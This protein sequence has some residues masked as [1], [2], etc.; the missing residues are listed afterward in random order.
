MLNILHKSMAVAVVPFVALVAATEAAANE[1]VAE[2]Y[3][4]KRIEFIIGSAAGGAYDQW[5]RLIARHMDRHI[6]GNPS[7]LPKNMPGAGQIIAT[8]HL[9]NRAPRDGTAIGMF[10]RNI[11]M[12]ALLKHP[13]I[14]F[15][16]SEFNWIG[17]P[18]LTNRVCVAR[19]GAKVQKGEDVFMHELLVGGAGI[20]TAV[21]NTPVVL[22]GVLGTKFKVVEG[23]KSASEV[24]LAIQRGEV[25]GICQ[26]MSGLE[27]TNPGWLKSGEFVP[28][29]SLEQKPV[30]GLGVPSVFSFT[31]TEEQRQMIA[32]FSGST[33]L[34]RPIAAPPE[35]PAERVTALRRAFDATM[36]DAQ[37]IAE[38]QRQGLEVTP[39]T[40][41]ELAALVEGLN[42]IRPEIVERVQAITQKK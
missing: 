7:L 19:K 17:S 33:E 6:P 16:T 30:P 34:G 24:T 21:S 31:K 42:R 5:A 2:F 14:K 37:F 8:N 22:N 32:F 26:T 35:V 28:L 23:Y 29:F 9:F 36:K 39:L 1:S 27:S 13:S 38:A 11:P 25:E 40:G 4:D 20:G 12:Q 41:E 15:N 10:S 3:K 18:E